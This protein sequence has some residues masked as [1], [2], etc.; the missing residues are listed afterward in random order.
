MAEQTEL[1][2]LQVLVEIVREFKTALLLDRDDLF[3]VS[4]LVM[5]IVQEYQDLVLYDHVLNAQLKKDKHREEAIKHLDDAT[6]YLYDK[7]DE[8]S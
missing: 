8:L 1:E 4:S 6:Q 2:R 7:I 5:D 3:R